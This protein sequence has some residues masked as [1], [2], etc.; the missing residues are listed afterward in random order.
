MKTKIVIV[1]FVCLSF[2]NCSEDKDDF[3]N[4]LPAITQEGK[5][6]AGCLVDGELVLKRG[7]TGG[8]PGPNSPFVIINTPNRERNF[9]ELGVRFVDNFFNEKSGAS[10]T[11][12]I[13]SE[14]EFKEGISYSL[15][16]FTM[17]DNNS[18]EGYLSI[19]PKDAVTSFSAVTNESYKGTLIITRLVLE[20]DNPFIA[21][22]FEFQAESSGGR[23]FNVTDGRFDLKIDEI[24]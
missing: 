14:A 12:S 9:W 3:P 24:N 16:E 22:T 7:R 6:T 2:I 21:G 23:V 19:S 10:V 1:L 20:G 5:D 13:K 15:L 8:I 18:S 17:N 4:E 11:I